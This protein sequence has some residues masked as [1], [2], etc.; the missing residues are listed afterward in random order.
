VVRTFRVILI[1]EDE[2]RTTTFVIPLERTPD[3]GS[4]VE[5][6]QGQRV[7]VRQVLSGDRDGLAGI[8]LAAPAAVDE[9]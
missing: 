2:D 3:D 5:L 4:V 9:P 7:I 8:V 1:E 6:P